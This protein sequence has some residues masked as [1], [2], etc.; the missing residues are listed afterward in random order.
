[1]ALSG[2]G[3][4][5]LMLSRDIVRYSAQELGLS[6]VASI[7]ASPCELG[8]LRISLPRFCGCFP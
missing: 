6:P 4:Q 5:F 3:R 7:S 1:V 8:R 2:A